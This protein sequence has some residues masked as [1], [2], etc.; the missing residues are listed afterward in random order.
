MMRKKLSVSSHPII[1][2]YMPMVDFLGKFLGPHCEVVLHDLSTPECSVVAICNGH[3]SGRSIG[4]P[5][6][7]LAL[8]F[9][10]DKVYQSCDFLRE[11][12]GALKNGRQVRSS[13]F[14]IKDP[15]GMLMGML[16]FNVDIDK[17]HCIR[18]ELDTIV[19]GYFNLGM[20]DKISPLEEIAP[21]KALLA[22]KETFSNSIDELITN[23]INKVLS[24]YTIPV[25][26][27]SPQERVAVIEELFHKGFFQLRGAVECIAQALCLSEAT[28]YRYLKSVQKTTQLE[29]KS[30]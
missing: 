15:D 30:N 16:C 19:C 25:D 27:L 4:A 22:E 7:D 1:Q 11:Y 10:Q 13:T 20:C 6:T 28:I 3:I 24:Q 8:K 2:S 12:E 29:K 21:P 14:F 23:N 5:L 26:R 17:L 18:K 9:L